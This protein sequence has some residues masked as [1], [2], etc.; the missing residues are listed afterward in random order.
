MI[1]GWLCLDFEKIYITAFLFGNYWHYSEWIP[2][3]SAYLSLL[4]KGVF[5]VS[6]NRQQNNLYLIS[7]IACKIL[8]HSKCEQL[9]LRMRQSVSQSSVFSCIVITN[10]LY[11]KLQLMIRSGQANNS[12]ENHCT[13]WD[14]REREFKSPHLTELL[15]DCYLRENTYGFSFLDLTI[16]A[17]HPNRSFNGFF[18][19]WHRPVRENPWTQLERA[20]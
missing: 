1:E 2:A 6:L 18:N 8:L 16:Q 17:S 3:K 14:Q 4:V 10:V 7:F 9:I 20:P 19:F 5:G 15:F 13:S 11:H 12:M